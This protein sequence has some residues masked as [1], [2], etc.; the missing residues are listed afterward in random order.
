[1]VVH[2]D[3]VVTEIDFQCNEV[4]LELRIFMMDT[5]E[6]PKYIQVE[7]LNLLRLPFVSFTKITDNVVLSHFF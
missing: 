7:L 4:T 5:V 6:L 3:S 1:M 2:V